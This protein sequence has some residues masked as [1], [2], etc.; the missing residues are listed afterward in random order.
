M[1]DL[2]ARL[3]PG[4]PQAVPEHNIPQ[5]HYEPTGETYID[6]YGDE[7]PAMRRVSDPPI[8]YGVVF[9]AVSGF[10]YSGVEVTKADH[11]MYVLDFDPMTPNGGDVTIPLA[12]ATG[13]V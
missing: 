10:T 1:I 4:G 7:R 13:V 8:P 9:S 2:W 6:E 3:L 5:W 11:S 12:T